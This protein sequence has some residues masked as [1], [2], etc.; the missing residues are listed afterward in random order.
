MNN[1]DGKLGIE[2]ERKTWENFRDWADYIP[3]RVFRNLQ[4]SKLGISLLTSTETEVIAAMPSYFPREKQSTMRPTLIFFDD[5]GSEFHLVEIGEPLPNLQLIPYALDD[6]LERILAKHGLFSLNI[7]E[8]FYHDV[9]GHFAG[10]EA[11]PEIAAAHR[12]AAAKLVGDSSAYLLASSRPGHLIVSKKR[13]PLLDYRA[14]GR[15]ALASEVQISTSESGR[16]RFGLISELVALN[17]GAG[18]FN[19]RDFRYEDIQ[20]LRARLRSRFSQVDRRALMNHFDKLYDFYREEVDFLGGLARDVGRANFG[21]ER[22]DSVETLGFSLPQIFRYAKEHELS[23]E[24][25]DWVEVVAQIESVLDFWTALPARDYYAAVD[26]SSPAFAKLAE[27]ARAHEFNHGIS[28]AWVDGRV[29]WMTNKRTPEETQNLLR[30]LETQTELVHRRMISWMDDL[31][32]RYNGT[33]ARLFAAELKGFREL[34]KSL[35][36]NEQDSA[37]L[38]NLIRSI[39]KFLA[40]LE[41]EY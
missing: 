15:F 32:M 17:L 36:L 40:D 9:I 11:H 2:G 25:D 30:Y 31:G 23:L 3:L 13:I 19:Q 26:E 18:Y 33:H 28:E 12:S 8:L 38:L 14:R 41:P 24:R 39:E 7:G 27:L 29:Y 22:L 37:V 21:F 5:R 34:L 35:N 1:I 6:S 20:G 10:F 16:A 4:Q